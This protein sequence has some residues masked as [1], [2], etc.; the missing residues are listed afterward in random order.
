[1]PMSVSAQTIIDSWMPT[2]HDFGDV[3]VGEA[4]S[5][6]FTVTVGDE[7]GYLFL[8]GVS[9]VANDQY[10]DPYLGDSFTIT[11]SPSDSAL[12]MPGT[13]FEVEVTFSPTSEGA[14]QAYLQIE[15]DESSGNEDIRIPLFGLGVAAE[16]DPVQEMADLIELFDA[17]VADG[18]IVGYGPGCSANRRL[19]AFRNILKSANDLINAGYYQLACGALWVADNKSDGVHPPPDFITGDNRQA[20]NDAIVYVRELLGCF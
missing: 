5:Q 18:T 9:L 12:I 13:S 7:G 10:S 4:E 6:I 8:Y 16:P 15:S 2:E 19:N 14:H 20:I 17:S 11:S 1:M 3:V